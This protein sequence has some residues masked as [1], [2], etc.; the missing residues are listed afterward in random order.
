MLSHDLERVNDKTFDSYMT[1]KRQCEK[2]KDQSE[3]SFMWSKLVPDRRFTRLLE[4]PGVGQLFVH[5]LTKT[6]Q[7]VDMS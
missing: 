1:A 6:W 3:A 7:T 4:L 5:F 2:E